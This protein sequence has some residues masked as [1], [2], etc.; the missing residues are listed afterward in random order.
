MLECNRSNTWSDNFATAVVIQLCY[1]EDGP[2][3][4]ITPD[5]PSHCHFDLQLKHVRVLKFAQCIK[6]SPHLRWHLE[7]DQ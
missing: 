4:F 5:L 3:L 6:Q 2:H 7:L 1:G